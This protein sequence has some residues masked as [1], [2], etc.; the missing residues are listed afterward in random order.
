M[1]ESKSASLRE[2]DTYNCSHPMQEKERQIFINFIARFLRRFLIE[3][4]AIGKGDNLGRNVVSVATSCAPLQTI[5]V[6]INR[7]GDKLTSIPHLI[8][9]LYAW[10]FNSA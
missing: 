7:T 6:I 4:V 3:V 1:Q 9:R 10:N 2:T 5:I 8:P